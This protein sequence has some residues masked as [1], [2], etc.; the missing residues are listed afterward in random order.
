MD[1]L[2]EIVRSLPLEGISEILA[3]IVFLW[4]RLVDGIPEE[5]LSFSVYVGASIIVLI[6][7]YF[8]TKILPKFLRGVI[9]I[10]SVAILF[11]PG[12]TIG[13]T[14]GSAPAIIGVAHHV[15]MGDFGKAL[16]GLLPILAVAMILFVA[17]ALWQMIRAAMLDAKAERG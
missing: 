11:T 13:D 17:G 5:E 4:I 16:S 6:L 8:F 2:K 14:G 15:L 10:L 3:K 7:L 12:G 9:F 1:W